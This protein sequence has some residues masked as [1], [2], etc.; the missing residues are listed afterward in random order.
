MTKLRERLHTFN[1][2]PGVLRTLAVAVAAVGASVALIAGQLGTA[3]PPAEGE[4]ASQTYTAT[5][6]IVVPDEEATEA[7]RVEAEDLVPIVYTTDDEV[8]N[9]AQQNVEAFFAA[10]TLEAF[11]DGVR[12]VETPTE[13]ETTTTTSTTSTTLFADEGGDPSIPV[14]LLVGSTE[15]EARS[16]LQLLGLNTGLG[17]DVEVTDASGRDRL[18]VTQDPAP[19]VLVTPGSTVTVQLGFVPTPATTTTTAVPP[20]TL[21]DQELTL[22]EEYGFLS[23]TTR[24]TFVSIAQ[25]DL[26]NVAAGEETELLL[27]VLL[28]DTVRVLQLQY[29]GDGIRTEELPGVLSAVA[30]GSVLLSPVEWPDRDA[31]A[32]AVADLVIFNLQANVRADPAATDAERTAARLAVE[33]VTVEYVDGQDIAKQGDIVTDIQ[34]QAI[35]QLLAGETQTPKRFAA[36]LVVASV[37]GLLV[38]FLR[39]NRPQLWAEPKLLF[40]FG[41]LIVLAAV[42]ARLVGSLIPDGNSALGYIM[43]A[44]AFGY[45]GGIL[46]DTRAAVLMSIP[47]AVFAGITTSDIGIVVFSAASVLA[48]LPFV[49]RAASMR[50]LRVAIL[51]TA[52]ITGPFA[53]SVAWFFNESNI[54]GE[55]GLFGFGGGLLGGL[56]GLGILPYVDNAFGLTTTLSLLD[57]TD[58]NHPALRLLEERAPGTFNHSML[59]GTLAGRAARAIDANPLLAEAA[60]YYHDLGKTE[61]PHLFIENQFGAANPHN[62]MAPEES[63]AVIRN[64][65]IDGV[66]LAR[67]YRIPP[68]VAVGIRQHHGT[69]LMRYFYHKALEDRPSDDVAAED[70]RH[71]GQKPQSREMAIV[72]LCDAIEAAARSLAYLDNPTADGLRKVVEQVVDEKLE[73]GQLDESPLTFGDLTKVKEALFDALISHYHHRIVY[74]TSR[75]PRPL[76][77]RQE[78]SP[79][80][81]H[82]SGRRAERSSRDGVSGG[83]GRAGVGGGGS[84]RPRRASNRPGRS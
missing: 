1:P 21:E 78:T 61:H 50:D 18:V 26:D 41:L 53:A 10:V 30:N 63:A 11:F 2:N 43:P 24:S 65:V 6:T 60:A 37:V 68:D 69:S 8:P 52:M 12:P 36:S 54:A 15:A 47:V 67:E 51:S 71:V 29:G 42:S 40:L 20:P 79:S 38:L 77:T 5:R 31:A 84:A 3:D 80:C 27:D 25:R 64:H 35:A 7:L 82:L 44:A 70:F 16:A 33:D 45:L 72:M 76:P 13:G 34:A 9:Q 23:E 49:S 55:A 83:H 66:R 58:R 22:E 48:P 28:F 81:E 46:F 75:G 39:R 14:P 32:D 19:D 73:D 74:P 57:L 56:I 62:W 59:V 17:A 4:P